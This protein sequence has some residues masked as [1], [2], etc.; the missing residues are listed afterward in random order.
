LARPGT[1]LGSDQSKGEINDSHGHLAGDTVLC[2]V[3][4]RLVEAVRSYDYVGR[5]GGEEFLIVLEECAATDLDAT[6]ERVRRH[7]AECP[8]DT[9][10]VQVSVTISLGLV[11]AIADGPDSL[12]PE[13][14][15]RAADAALYCAKANGRNRAETAVLVS[16]AVGAAPRSGAINAK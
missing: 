6:A 9:G 13:D 8:V 3:S 7:I 16:H 12:V 14:L 5:Y 1:H 10:P 11:C 4:R 15:V 2:E